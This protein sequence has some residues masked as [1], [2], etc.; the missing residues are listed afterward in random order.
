MVESLVL[1]F[2]L[3]T[4][5]A[6]GRRIAAEL[7]LPFGPFPDFL[8]GLKNQQILAYANS[9][10]ANDYVYSLDRH[11][12]GA[13]QELSGRVCL[14]RH[15]AGSVRRLSGVR[16]RPDDH[17]R[18]PQGRRP[19]AGVFRPADRRGDLSLARPGHQLGPR[20]FPLRIPRQRQDQHRRAHH[21]LLRHDR[22]DPQGH[23][24]RRAD[25]Q[26]LRHGES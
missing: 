17:D 25:H 22:L 24:G 18:A 15:G 21:S 5:M 11:R 8:R 9:A 7:G 23:P 26:A 13:G 16:G 10:S 1:K 3:N 4:G 12:P 20:A 14:C 2:L 19:E 6:S